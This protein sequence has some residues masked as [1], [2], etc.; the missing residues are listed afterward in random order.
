LGGQVTFVQ[1]AVRGQAHRATKVATPEALHGAPGRVCICRDSAP[2][3]GVPL[4]VP[5]DHDGNGPSVKEC[6]EHIFITTARR[7]TYAELKGVAARVNECERKGAT[8][9]PEPVYEPAK[10]ADYGEP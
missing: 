3:T 5:D 8:G 6:S 9:R 4:H 1:T 7:C 10:C 2:E